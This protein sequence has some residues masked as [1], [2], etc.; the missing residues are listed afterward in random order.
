MNR[1]QQELHEL[2]VSKGFW[3]VSTN[4]GEKIALIHSELSEALEAYRKGDEDN[5]KEELADTMIRLFD[6]AGHMKFS[7]YDE[8]QKKNSFNKT[9]PYLHGKKF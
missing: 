7:L 6:L 9:R 5:F 4:I 8:I 2:A 1:L 3:K